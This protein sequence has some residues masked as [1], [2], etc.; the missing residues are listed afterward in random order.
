MPVRL[1]EEVARVLARAGGGG[2]RGAGAAALVERWSGAVGETIARNAWPA[3]VQR[4]GTLVVHTSSSTWAQELTQLEPTVRAQLGGAAPRLRFVVGPLPEPDLAAAPNV[5]RSVHIPS[6][7]ELD[8][9]AHMADA[10]EDAALREAVS[11]ACSL[12]LAA[13]RAGRSDRPV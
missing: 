8:E 10:I 3:R 2:D 6:A 5:R 11:R 1:G 4:D 13:A 12:S 9:A 7:A